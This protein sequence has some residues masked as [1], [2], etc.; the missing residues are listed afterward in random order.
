[1][2]DS[3]ASTAKTLTL[4]ALIIQSIFF[5]IGLISA[6]FFL[7]VTASVTTTSPTGATVVGP[8]PTFL[9]SAFFSVIF[10]IGL[11]WILLDYFLVYK[12]LV[13]EKVEEAETPSLVLGILQ[14]LFGGI[15]TGILLIV[16]YVKIRD[17]ERNRRQ[18]PQYVVQSQQ[19]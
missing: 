19:N 13:E 15:I 7:A 2:L 11:V 14:L 18:P 8:P 12:K 10:L 16:A 1:M 9:F 5:A 17:S 3:D 6:I 4:V